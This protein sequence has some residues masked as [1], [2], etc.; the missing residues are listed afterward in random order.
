MHPKFTLAILAEEILMN[1]MWS[2]IKNI[3]NLLN[4]IKIF[5]QNDIIKI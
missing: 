1:N 4:T 3:S 2:V 5:L